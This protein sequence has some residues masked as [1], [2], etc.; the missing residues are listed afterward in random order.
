[1]PCSMRPNNS[2][3][4]AIYRASYFAGVPPHNG[5]PTVSRLMCTV[6]SPPTPP[7]S[8][9][10]ALK[11]NLRRKIHKAEHEGLR[12]VIDNSA[13]GDFYAIY[14]RNL[15]RLGTPV[16]TKSY[17]TTLT[18]VL[19]D[20]VRFF[21]LLHNDRL[22]G[23]MLAIDH[24]A[25]R[26]SLYVAVDEEAMRR[27]GTYALY[28]AVIEDCC[29]SARIVTLDLGR[30][31]PHSGNHRFKRQWAPDLWIPYRTY[32]AVRQS[33]AA[34]AGSAI[35]KALWARL[36]LALCNAVGPTVR[37]HQPFG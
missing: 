7:N 23:G 9:W 25:A 32:G 15:R 16:M 31:V 10:G 3:M 34:S 21:T 30:S 27:Y 18:A 17:F 28:W 35:A 8:L 24:G 20:H 14:A 29:R 12:M 26:T 19:A 36:P 1:M 37:K 22:T 11:S 5:R 6:C 33:L 2:G 4:I 13:V